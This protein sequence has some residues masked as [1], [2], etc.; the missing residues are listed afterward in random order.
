MDVQRQIQVSIERF[1]KAI[2]RAVL[3]MTKQVTTCMNEC[4][5]RYKS[6]EQIEEC[7]QACQSE[8]KEADDDIQFVIQAFQQKF[9]CFRSLFRGVGA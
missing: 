8:V 7:F 3:P 5:S 4:S 9:C 2:Q 6:P 1:Q